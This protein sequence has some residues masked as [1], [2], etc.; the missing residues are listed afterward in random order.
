M[1]SLQDQMAEILKI[2]FGIA[3]KR[4]VVMYSKPY[5]E[6]FDHLPPPPKFKVPEFSKFS[7]NDN[8]STVEH[9]SQYTAQL[10]IAAIAKHIKIWLFSLSLTGPAFGWYT[11]LAPGSITSWKQLEEQFHAQF[12][13]GSDE[14]TLSDLTALRQRTGETVS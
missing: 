8:T 3:P 6:V 9:I 11:S 7:G 5:S 14:A 13:S 2:K 10:D 12:F 4:G 1:Q